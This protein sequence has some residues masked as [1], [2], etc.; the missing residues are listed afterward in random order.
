MLKKMFGKIKAIAKQLV[1]AFFFTT[2]MIFLTIILFGNKI[3]KTINVFTKLATVSYLEEPVERDIKLNKVK[4][5]LVM[6]PVHGELFGSVVIPSVGIDIKLYNG[7]TLDVLRYGA[8]HH[9]GSYY[10][11]EGGTIII[12]AHNDWGMFYNLPKVKV[13]DIVT[14]KTVY[15]TYNYK[16][17]RTE[18]A[19][20]KVLGENL[21]IRTDLE[22]IMLY[23]CYPVGTPGFK[24]NRFV[25]YGRL[26]GEENE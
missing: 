3:N 7:E 20:A 24:S 23:T 21:K 9:A 1:V 5:R 11:G 26:V 25:V 12:A 8:G 13:G 18:I 17:D 14:I 2:F 19:N 6:H 10:P 22:E 16:V 4:K 15:G